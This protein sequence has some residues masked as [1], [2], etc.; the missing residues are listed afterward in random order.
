ML[1]TVIVSLLFILNI[2]KNLKKEMLLSNKLLY[3]I[4]F[5][6]IN[7]KDRGVVIKFLQNY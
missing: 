3:I 7:D 6:S 1:A 4:D 5:E 2:Y